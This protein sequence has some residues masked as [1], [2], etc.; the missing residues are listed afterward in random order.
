MPG[1]KMI[2]SGLQ[3][4]QRIF[5]ESQKAGGRGGPQVLRPGDPMYHGRTGKLPEEDQKKVKRVWAQAHGTAASQQ[6]YHDWDEEFYSSGARNFGLLTAGTAGLS[7]GVGELNRRG[8]KRQNEKLSRQRVRKW[9]VNEPFM[10]TSDGKSPHKVSTLSAEP[11]LKTKFSRRARFGR[12]LLGENGV[13]TAT[14]ILSGAAL[15]GV[16]LSYREHKRHEELKRKVGKALSPSERVRLAAVRNLKLKRESGSLAF[17]RSRAARDDFALRS[18]LKRESFQRRTW[19]KKTPQ[20]DLR[21]SRGGP[22]NLPKERSLTAQDRNVLYG[23]PYGQGIRKAAGKVVHVSGTGIGDSLVARCGVS[24]KRGAHVETALPGTVHLNEGERWCPKCVGLGR[25]VR[26]ALKDPKKAYE[27]H[28]RGAQAKGQTPMS[29]DDFVARAEGPAPSRPSA[30]PRRRPSA[31]L[32]STRSS[33]T[34]TPGGAS[35]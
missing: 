1:P 25:L 15:A 31:R 29:Y 32:A 35:R 33:R 26:K 16:P 10:I 12:H 11:H 23:R 17:T 28:V 5:H 27:G 24:R 3:H 34:H 22:L 4:G 13:L 6:R 9:D 8:L 30:R 18:R 21:L 20:G 14:A 19:D 2:E 7:L